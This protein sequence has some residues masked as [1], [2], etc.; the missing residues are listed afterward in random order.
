MPREFENKAV[1]VYWLLHYAGPVCTI[2]GNKGWFDTRGVKSPTGDD[3]GKLHYCICPNGQ[4]MRHH[5]FPLGDVQGPGGS[6]H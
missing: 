2:C 1:S 3:V 6:A 4:T 5:R